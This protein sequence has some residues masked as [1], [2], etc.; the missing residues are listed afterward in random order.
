MQTQKVLCFLL[1]EAD[2][3][4]LHSLATQELLQASAAHGA[5]H[6]GVCYTLRNSH[7]QH[8][9]QSQVP[10]TSHFDSNKGSQLET[11][12]LTTGCNQP[13]V[14]DSDLALHCKTGRERRL[15]PAA[16][17]GNT[18]HHDAKADGGLVVV[19]EEALVAAQHDPGVGPQ[20]LEVG[21][22]CGVAAY[23][24]HRRNL[25]VHFQSKYCPLSKLFSLKQL[26]NSF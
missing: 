10:P 8:P 25:L 6:N 13:N 23:Q 15:G 7:P 17:L 4:C 24:H 22:V 21:C 18:E 16:A 1:Y 26:E 19:L 2:P 3:C 14:G 12:L 11:E 5:L 20:A 9:A